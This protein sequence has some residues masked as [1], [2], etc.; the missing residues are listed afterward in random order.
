MRVLVFATGQASLGAAIARRLA[1]GDNDVVLVTSSVAE[2]VGT[3]PRNVTCDT[4]D[5]DSDELEASIGALVQ[6]VTPIDALVLA[7]SYGAEDRHSLREIEVDYWNRILK[8]NATVGFLA[9]RDAAPLLKERGGNVVILVP[10]AAR[11]YPILGALAFTAARASLIGLMRTL[12][13]EL[14]PLGVRVNGVAC[15][16]EPTSAGAGVTSRPPDSDD[17]AG[18]VSFLLS[19]QSTFITGTTVDVNG[20]RHML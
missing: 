16:F 5:A 15:N 11:G 12:A 8:R 6:K 19:S 9:A 3:L 10:E 4:I 1:S 20:G 14:G 2:D 7:D 13:L 18:V 17:V